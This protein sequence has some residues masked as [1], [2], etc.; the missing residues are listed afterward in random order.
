MPKLACDT[1]G[2]QQEWGLQ[3]VYKRERA[4]KGPSPCSDSANCE[5][6]WTR[7]ASRSIPAYDGQRSLYT[8]RQ[9]LHRV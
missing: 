2:L 8:T 4:P 1:I 3:L 9:L 7:K 6:V 5:D